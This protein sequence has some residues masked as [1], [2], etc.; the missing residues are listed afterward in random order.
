MRCIHSFVSAGLSVSLVCRSPRLGLRR[1][2]Q[3][4]AGPDGAGVVDARGSRRHRRLRQRPDEDRDG[5]AAGRHG[6][7][8][9]GDAEVRNASTDAVVWPCDLVGP[10]T[11]PDTGVVYYIADFT[12]YAESGEFYVA[13]PGLVENGKAA[14]SAKFRIA[15]DVF[16]DALTRAMIGFYGQRCGTAVSIT[17]DGNTWSH[18]ICHQQDGFQDHLPDALKTSTPKPSL[19]GWHDAGDYGKYTTNGAFAVGMMLMAWERFPATLGALSLPIPEHGGAIPDYLDE[20][21][22]QLDWLL[23]TQ[24]PDGSVSFKVTA[25]NFEPNVLPEDDGAR[26]STPTS[27]P[28]P[29]GTWSPCWRRRRASTSPTTPRWRPATSRRRASATTIWRRRRCGTIPT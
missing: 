23:T 13:V 14:R 18:K 28:R 12:A 16:R 1:V 22:W 26:R 19:R 10:K 27:A 3:R 6:H 17:L 25:Q 11:D 4:H 21:K 15:P 8:R 9:P 24:F 20:I 29:P 7:H 2:V 5:G